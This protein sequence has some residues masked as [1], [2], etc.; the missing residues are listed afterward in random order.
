M[1]EIAVRAFDAQSMLREL[2]GAARSHEKGDVTSRFEQ[3]PAEIS[4]DAA[5]S[6]D[7]YSHS[8]VRYVERQ[9]AAGW[10][11]PDRRLARGYVA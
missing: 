4:P 1:V 2:R 6:H 7:E 3:T 9:V 5:R 8:K 11:Q 10:R